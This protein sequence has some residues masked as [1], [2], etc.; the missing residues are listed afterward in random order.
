[1]NFPNQLGGGCDQ[2]ASNRGFQEIEAVCKPGPNFDSCSGDQLIGT[3]GAF[4]R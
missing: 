2:S 1:M 4:L 3:G